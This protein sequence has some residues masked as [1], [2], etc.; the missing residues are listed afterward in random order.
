MRKS[1]SW[2]LLVFLLLAA[3]RQ[4]HSD[5]RV[6]PAIPDEPQYNIPEIDSLTERIR[7]DPN[8]PEHYFR[9]H[10]AFLNHDDPRRAFQDLSM[11]IALDSSALHYYDA[12]AELAL[13]TGAAQAAVKAYQQLLQRNPSDKQ[14]VIKLSKVYYLQK[15]YTHSLLQLAR[16]EELDPSDAEIW[17]IRGLNLKEMQDT[18]RAIAAFQKAVSLKPE[19]YDAYIQLGLLHSTRPSSLAALYYDNAIRLD[20]TSTEA[21]YNKGKFFQDRALRAFDAR[22]FDEA[23]QDFEQAKAIYRQLISISPQY[24]PAYFNLGFIYAKQD[25]LDKAYR[26][27]DLAIK[28]NPAYAE[29]YYYRGLMALQKGNRQQAEADFRQ[30]ISLK[31]DFE[32]AAAELKQLPQ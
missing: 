7:K 21:Y 10:Q 30:C 6:P 29:A 17:F 26:M 8:N 4:R 11:A 19:F 5:S 16:A 9:R 18:V 3:C 25:S 24:E 22:R 32:K 28:M 14:A 31:P 13:K 1:L 12:M 27:F 20:S 15:D 2:A 23:H